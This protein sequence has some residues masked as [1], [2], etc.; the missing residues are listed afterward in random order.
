MFFLP[1]QEVGQDGGQIGGGAHKNIAAH[2]SV[3][4]RGASDVDTAGLSMW[5]QL[6][7]RGL[8]LLRKVGKG[9][10]RSRVSVQS[11]LPAAM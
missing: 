7:K 3:E 6:P 9:V 4:G 10:A 11:V 1:G 5:N 2:E 8:V